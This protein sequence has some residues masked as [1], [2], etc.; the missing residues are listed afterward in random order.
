VSWG[1]VIGSGCSAVFVDRAAEDAVAVDRGVE[2]D[3][4]DGGGGV[5]ASGNSEGP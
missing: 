2:R 3:D 4:D 5:I 1:F